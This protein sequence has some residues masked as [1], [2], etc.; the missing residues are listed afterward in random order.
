MAYSDALPPNIIW[1]EDLTEL[2]YKSTRVNLSQLRK[3]LHSINDQ[4]H[5]LLTRLS[6][7]QLLPCTIPTDL[8]DDLTKDEAGHSFLHHP[9]LTHHHL[10]IVR[11]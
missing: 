11:Q 7:G 1:K 10:S 6:G 3:G 9:S 4:V 8:D 2:T 5:H